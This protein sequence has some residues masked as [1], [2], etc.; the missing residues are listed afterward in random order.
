MTI[1][2]VK[3]AELYKYCDCFLEYRNF[4]DVLI[5]YKSLRCNKNY[6][7]KFHEKLKE[8]FVSTHK[9]SNYD[10][11]KFILLLRKEFDPAKLLSAPRLTW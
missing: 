7:Q 8:R 2:N 11:N 4:K 10:N 5:E 1:K 6:Q 3:H 9:F